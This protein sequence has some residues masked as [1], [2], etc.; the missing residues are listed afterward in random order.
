M[1][2]WL[3]LQD[4]IHFDFSPASFAFLFFAKNRISGNNPKQSP[5]AF[6]KTFV[7]IFREE[8][9]DVAQYIY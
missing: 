4:H 7:H 3:F 5:V 8:N 1:N 9:Y 6:E 2:L